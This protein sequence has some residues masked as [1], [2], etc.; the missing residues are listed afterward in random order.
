ML[1]KKNGKD[2][3]YAMK[4]IKKSDLIKHHQVAHT[5]T[6]RHCL[7]KIN[8]PFLVHLQ[9]AFQTPEKLYMILDFMAGGELFYWMKQQGIYNINIYIIQY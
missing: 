3:T 4:T 5:V 8:N 1:V 9:Y 7:H 6:E 2:I